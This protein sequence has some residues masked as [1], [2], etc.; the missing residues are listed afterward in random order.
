MD[1]ENNGSK[2]Y[3]KKMNDLGVNTHIF[4]NTHFEEKHTRLEKKTWPT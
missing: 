1:G 3:L 2:P 4:G